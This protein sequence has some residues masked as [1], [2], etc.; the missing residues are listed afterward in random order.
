MC[1]ARR[2]CSCTVGAATVVKPRFPWLLVVV[3]GP[4]EARDGLPGVDGGAVRSIVRLVF[5]QIAADNLEIMYW[6]RFARSPLRGEKRLRSYAERAFAAARFGDQTA[7]GT[8]LLVDNDHSKHDH[9]REIQVALDQDAHLAGRS[10]VGVACEMLEAWLLADPEVCDPALLPSRSPDS[11]WGKK[12]DPA[13]NYP[14][15]VLRRLVL[16]PRGWHHRDATNAWDPAR[17][18][19]RS[20]SLAA[21]LDEVTALAER[22]GVR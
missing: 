2:A 15:H 19:A 16:K 18:R 1:T 14:K 21:F 11:L 13:S 9:R 5:G 17:A 7:Y 22:Q 6:G 12:D 8:L 4:S 20:L 3:D 10:A